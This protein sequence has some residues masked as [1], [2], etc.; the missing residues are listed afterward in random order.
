MRI[1]LGSTSPWRAE[2]MR[3]IVSDF[4]V[5]DPR[6]DEKG[7]RDPNPQVLT[8]KLARAKSK[9]L[10]PRVVG[11]AVLITADQVVV[12]DG[13]TRGK[14][15]DADEARRFIRSYRD[16][17]IVCV[18]ALYGYRMKTG[19]DAAIWSDAVVWLRALDD[20]NIEKLVADPVTMQCAGA[21]A[22]GHP[23]WNVYIHGIQGGVDGLYGL[24]KDLTRTLIEDLS[25]D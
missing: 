3:S 1:I 17:P 4:E 5:M 22:A 15:R 6:V 16:H 25:G 11:D 20:A 21:C 18:N 14:P 8:M 10:Q 19:R 12:C 23:N 24:P 13:E 2:I 7:I 9:A